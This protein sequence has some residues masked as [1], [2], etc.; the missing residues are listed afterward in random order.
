MKMKQ[1]EALKVSLNHLK[2]EIIWRILDIETMVTELMRLEAD[3]T[4]S[5]EGKKAD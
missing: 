3:R 4:E 2:D 1:R 5:C